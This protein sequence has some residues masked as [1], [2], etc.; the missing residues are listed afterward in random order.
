MA[1]FDIRMYEL[2]ST[3]TFIWWW[4]GLSASSSRNL[5]GGGAYNQRKKL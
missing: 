1:G 4:S 5:T 2:A 3:E